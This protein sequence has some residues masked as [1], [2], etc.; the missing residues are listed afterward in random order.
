MKQ[1][2]AT[3]DTTNKTYTPETKDR[4]IA[5]QRTQHKPM[6]SISKQQIQAIP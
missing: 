1:Q 6:Q 2:A 5:E 3:Q 4:I